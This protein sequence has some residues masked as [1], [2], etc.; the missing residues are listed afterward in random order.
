MGSLRALGLIG[1]LVAL[2]LAGG[3]ARNAVTVERGGQLVAIGMPVTDA[4][5]Q[6]VRDVQAVNREASIEIAVADPTCQWPDIRIATGEPP[7]GSIICGTGPESVPFTMVNEA[8]VRPTLALIDA[9]LAYLSAVDDTITAAPDASATM[10]EL[11]LVDVNNL[12]AGIDGGQAMLNDNQVAAA[13][14]LAA[15][16]GAL[17]QERAQ[18]ERLRLVER[19]AGDVAAVLDALDRDLALWAGRSA[20]AS[21]RAIDTAFAVRAF[22]LRKAMAAQ[23]PND[24]SVMADNQWRE[25][26]L[27]WA[28]VKDRQLASAEVPVEIHKALAAL[29]LAHRDYVRILDP[30][31]RLTAADRAA[32]A[33][34]TRARLQEAL[35]TIS[36][37]IR[38][39]L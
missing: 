17:V 25:F 8:A 33:R 2:L 36:G 39:F 1:P 13:T 14:G 26:L 12:V 20:P 38:A 22:Q 10:L 34:I 4:A 16:I 15:I 32:M 7:A 29:R 30:E 35:S 23:P 27:Q 18:V 28:A 19:Q 21:L 3:C 37:A 9:M 11:A 24:R 31:A 5:R 6:V